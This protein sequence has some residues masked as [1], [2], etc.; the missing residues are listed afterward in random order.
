LRKMKEH[1]PNWSIT[2]SLTSIFYEIVT[3]WQARLK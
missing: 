1:Y 3:A 2:K